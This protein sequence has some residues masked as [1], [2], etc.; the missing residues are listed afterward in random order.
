[1][2]GPITEPEGG[3]VLGAVLGLLRADAPG[4]ITRAPQ[5]WPRWAVL[6]PHVLAAASHFDDL[7]GAAQEAAGADASW[8]LDRA[9]TYLQVH[10]RL[11]EARPL[12]ER[13]LAIDEAAYGPDHP[14][15]AI[16]LN[17]LATILRALGLLAEARPLAERALAIDEAAYGPDHPTV[18]I[19]LNNL[20]TILKDLDLLAEARPL[21][22]RALAITEAAY[23]PDHPTVAILRANL[24]RSA[25]D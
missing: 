14:A 24:D 25:I 20:A 16:D 5:D 1:M 3:G 2:P 17:N 19:R 9:A 15:V 21:A 18:A 22:E 6:L 4:Q 13:A 10:A 8:L 7:R 11:A 23:G 12:A